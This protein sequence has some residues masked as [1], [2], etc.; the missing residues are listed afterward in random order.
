M[1]AYGVGRN[2]LR[3]YE[4]LGLLTGMSR[5][6]AGYRRYDTRHLG[7]L[8]FIL[9]AKRIGFTLNEIRGLLKL[10]HAKDRVTCGVV[11]VEVSKKLSHIESELKTLKAK[12]RFLAAF[13]KTCS[14]KD[15]SGQ[16][17]ILTSGFS[18]KA[19]CD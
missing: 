10:A 14:S 18:D 11:T 12:K 13:M 17:E 7:D 6:E 15:E 9:E 19:C 8:K 5:T 1:S 2:T 16:C 3:L 4:S